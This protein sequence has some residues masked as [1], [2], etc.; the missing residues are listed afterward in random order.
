VKRL[1]IAILANLSRGYGIR[2]LEYDQP[3]TIAALSEALSA[4]HDVVAIECGVNLVGWIAK[5]VEFAPDLIFSVAEGFGRA[6]R[7]A[8][9]PALYEEL[10]L[11]YCGSDPSTLLIT[12][13][14]QLTKQVVARAGVR[15]PRSCVVDTWDDLDAVASDLPAAVIVKPNTEGSSI[16]I[17]GEAVVHD[18]TRLRERVRLVWEELGNVALVEEFIPGVDVSMS[19]VE[20][21]GPTGVFGPVAYYPDSNVLDSASKSPHSPRSVMSFDLR[22][23]T[24]AVSALHSAMADAVQ[25]LDV[26]G[27]GRADFRVTDSGVVYFLEMNAQAEIKPDRSDFIVTV[28]RAGHSYKEIVQHIVEYAWTHPRR[29]SLAGIVPVG[30]R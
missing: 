24:S 2:D 11:R 28:E 1:S 10:G 30:R 15:T 7:E 23:A 14:K 9:Y 29:P 25:A 3:S 21:L 18:M 6:A 5:L 4:H 22:S 17:D 27:Y 20:G 8:F 16:G 12:H 19:F 26:R 13:N